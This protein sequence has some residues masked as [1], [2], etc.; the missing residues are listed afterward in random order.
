MST[1]PIEFSS[2]SHSPPLN[3]RAPLT[4]TSRRR[5]LSGP[6]PFDHNDSLSINSNLHHAAATA[7][8]T[9]TIPSPPHSLLSSA[10]KPPLRPATVNEASPL[11]PRAADDATEIVDLGACV[12]LARV[13]IS[14]RHPNLV[15]AVAAVHRY[16]SSRT[17]ESSA[18]VPD[19]A[20]LAPATQSSP[21]ALSSGQVSPRLL[22]RSFSAG[23]LPTAAAIRPA[24]VS[25]A[26]FSRSP[27]AGNSSSDASVPMATDARIELKASATAAG[28][29]CVEPIV[30]GDPLQCCIY[31][32]YAFLVRIPATEESAQEAHTGVTA[33]F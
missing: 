6:P 5:S 11:P 14:L 33:Y 25:I 21:K 26:A 32:R 18:A 8:P 12:A 28:D 9:R 16:A 27:P 22:Q 31:G 20:T 29:L 1:S 17:S 3:S 7:S 15:R 30:V 24:S 13:T 19:L 10:S 4:E 23:A 2:S